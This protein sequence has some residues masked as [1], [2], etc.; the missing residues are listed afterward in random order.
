MPNPKPIQLPT[1]K[2]RPSGDSSSRSLATRLS[3]YAIALLC[4]FLVV[5]GAL[6][7]WALYAEGLTHP[8]AAGCRALILYPAENALLAAGGCRL[9]TDLSAMFRALY[10]P[11]IIVLS[12]KLGAEMLAD[13]V[14]SSGGREARRQRTVGITFIL[15]GITEWTATVGLSV[16]DTSRHVYSGS[17]SIPLIAITGAAALVFFSI[18][19]THVRRATS[20][21]ARVG[22]PARP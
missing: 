12:T 8:G 20:R 9:G 3:R 10:Q 2:A 1:F 16:L 21:H 6:V 17:T 7:L 4:G 11:G 5:D 13:A 18:A 15:L 14:H 22:R 19:T